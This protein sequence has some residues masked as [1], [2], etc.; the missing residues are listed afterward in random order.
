MENKEEL[1]QN[2]KVIE[3]NDRAKNSFVSLQN[4]EKI[5]PNGAKAVYDFNLDIQ[6]HEFIV[7]V[8]PS[9]CGKS[10]TLRMIGG[11]E[12]ITNGELFIGQE[13]SNY[14]SSKDRKM[15]MVFQSY[16]LYPQM[17]V[18][19]NI[20]YPLKINKYPFQQEINGVIQTVYRKL[21]KD[22][23]DEKVFS[24]A[25]IL[26]LGQ[27]LNRFPRQLSGGQM[28]RVALGRAIV[29]NVPLFLMDEPLS[30]LD[31]K[32]RMTMRSEIVKLHN[33][34]GATTIYVTHDQIE[35][36]TMATRI[37]VM[38]KGFVQQIDTPEEI[39]NNPKNLFVAKF[40]GSPSMN[41]FNG[42]Y[43]NGCITFDGGV[44]ISL[45]K[46][47]AEKHKKF[48]ED[49]ISE[50]EKILNNFDVSSEEYVKKIQSALM[51]ETSFIELPKK[52]SFAKIRKLIE[53]FKKK[54]V[55]QGNPEEKTAQIKLA[56]LKE[57]LTGEHNLIVGIRPEK[58]VA[59]RMDEAVNQKDCVIVEVA[60]AEL[61]GAEYHVH[62]NLFGNDTIVKMDTRQKIGV[63]DKLAIE[64]SENSFKIFDPVT[65]DVI[66]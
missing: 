19:E 48:Y 32:L 56:Q 37:V 64:L 38:S 40:I 45:N 9:G 44:K 51:D 62:F 55:V 16:A 49:K 13:F 59:K 17:T 25:K 20:S 41:I 5:Y 61:M 28:Q 27:Y 1:L 53:K 18:Y 58:L 7:M 14:K 23:I 6:E 63:N 4:I 15:A 52:K 11:L 29:K 30:N 36:M 8:G 31:A 2:G 24:A 34:I 42:S 21:T 57:A 22:E 26:D 54:E 33:R 35:A 65:G 60:V 12:D 66:Q 46:N 39:Y 3:V 43:N 47:F 50:F 10:T